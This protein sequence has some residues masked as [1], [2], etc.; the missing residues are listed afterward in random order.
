MNNTYITNATLAV[1]PEAEE[2]DI[3]LGAGECPTTVEVNGHPLPGVL[4][5]AR[6]GSMEIPAGAHVT[7]GRGKVL[8][9][10]LFDLHA[11]IEIPGRSKR[12]CIMRAGQAAIQGGVWGMLVM[13]SP[14][15]CFD[16]TATLDSFREAV[17]ARSAAEMVPACCISSGMQGEQ[18]APYNTLATTRG[19]SVL[20]D[21]QR[22]PANTL[23]LY[24]AMQ[25]AAELGLTFAVRGDVPALSEHT[26]AHPGATAYRL[27]LR[28]CPPC[29]EEIGIETLI[30][31]AEDTGAKLHLQLVSTA[32]SVRIIRRA[33]ERGRAKLTAEVALHHLLYTHEDIGDYDTVYKTVPPLRDR[34]DCKALIDGVKDGTIDCIVSAHTPCT[35]FAKKQDF[36]TAPQGMVALDHYLPAL[37]TYLVKPGLLSWADI[38]RACCTNPAGIAN[39][40]DPEEDVPVCAPLLLFDPA[41]ERVV[42]EATLPCGTLNTPLLGHTLLGD[43]TLPLR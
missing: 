43:V 11:H 12:E 35:P 19:V 6:G 42:S 21:G 38:V 3:C 37:Y 26:Y 2:L 33:K 25:Y 41:A 17:A 8:M 9:P 22:Y 10:A 5:V 14:A 30:R 36:I 29:A 28:P 31:M 23:M 13:P 7:D 27:G 34:A 32:E 15:F 39:P 4:S 18:Q 40:H 20:S 16:N 24:R 1:V